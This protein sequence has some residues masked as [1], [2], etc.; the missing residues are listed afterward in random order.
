MTVYTEGFIFLNRKISEVVL[1]VTCKTVIK[2]NMRKNQDKIMEMILT[3]KRN[4]YDM[5]MF[6][7]LPTPTSIHTL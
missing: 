4:G 7:I 5:F 3:E 1:A 2:T 6:A